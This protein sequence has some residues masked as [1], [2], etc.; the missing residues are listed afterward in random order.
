MSVDDA[1][2]AAAVRHEHVLARA[3]R[4]VTHPAAEV[5][6]LAAAF[7]KQHSALRFVMSQIVLATRLSVDTAV[8]RSGVRL[9]LAQHE[10]AAE[11]LGHQMRPR[12]R[13]RLDH[14]VV[15]VRAHGVV[16]DVELF[17]DL[18]AAV[19]HCHQ[20]DDLELALR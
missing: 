8:V 2:L 4:R 7:Y 11:G 1:G 18:R 14:R 15:D 10:P 20:P 12:P 5:G 9:A 16:A 6:E 13:V 19:A 17:G 3:E